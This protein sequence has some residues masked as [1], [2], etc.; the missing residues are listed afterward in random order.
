MIE[1]LELKSSAKCFTLQNIGGT[2][3]D[4]KFSFFSVCVPLGHKEKHRH[5]CNL[6]KLIL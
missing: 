1:D 5:D 2:L 6:S 3:W 4:S